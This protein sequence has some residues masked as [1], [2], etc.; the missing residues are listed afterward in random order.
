MYDG[1]LMAYYGIELIM[2]LG[3]AQS[4]K[5]LIVHE[6]LHI[7]QFNK[8]FP[9]FKGKYGDDIGSNMMA[10][11]RQ[12]FF[13]VFLE[14]LS[15]VAQEKVYPEAPRPGIMK[16]F[17]PDYEKNFQV[18]TEEFLK[19]TEYFDYKKYARYFHDPSDD[20]FIPDKFGYWLGYQAV[21]RLNE[22][23]SIEEMMDWTVEK[24]NELTE[25]EIKKMICVKQ[26]GFSTAVH[27]P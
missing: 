11:S 20:P 21:K 8:L 17:I 25:A 1:D 10:L 22:N 7:I 16:K 3:K 12:P 19:D 4:I 27:F 6:T 9:R 24:A 5:A 26:G 14:G 18:Y 23:H 2:K 13:M 15:V